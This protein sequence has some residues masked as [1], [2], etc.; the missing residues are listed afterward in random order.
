MCRHE[1]CFLARF[2]TFGN[3]RNMAFVTSTLDRQIEFVSGNAG[4]LLIP[5]VICTA[6]GGPSGL[7]HDDF[8]SARV[9]SLWP[10]LAMVGNFSNFTTAGATGPAWAVG[11]GQSDLQ[12]LWIPA[13]TKVEI[14]AMIKG[15]APHA[16]LW[17][18]AD[19][20]S[21]RFVQATVTWVSVMVLGWGGELLSA[22]VLFAPPSC[23]DAVDTSASTDAGAA[24]NGRRQRPWPHQKR[25][26]EDG[27]AGL[28]SFPHNLGVQQERLWAPVPL[29]GP[30]EVWARAC[31][32]RAA[33]SLPF[34]RL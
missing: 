21:W 1:L 19:P 7:A 18:W 9:H 30:M 24:T 3:R 27:P 20:G 33:P 15:F 23:S 14:D 12:N 34:P 11:F 31:A 32:G 13:P 10:R 4:K 26:V 17:A 25:L 8:V 2:A 29:R 28:P 6:A 16:S 22:A 5:S